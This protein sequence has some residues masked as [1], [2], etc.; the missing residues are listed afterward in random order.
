VVGA[1]PPDPI[2]AAIEDEKAVLQ[3]W[4][5]INEMPWDDQEWWRLND[6]YGKEWD[7]AFDTMVTTA[8]TTREGAAAKVRW[9]AERETHLDQENRLRDFLNSLLTFLEA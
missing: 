9:Y 2:Y 1:L 7:R 4:D 3:K 8:P 6:A 5:T